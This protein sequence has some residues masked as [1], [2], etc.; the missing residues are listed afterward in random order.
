MSSL[1]ARHSR[2]RRLLFALSILFVLAALL[3]ATTPLLISGPGRDFVLDRINA[4][5]AGRIELDRL[6]LDWTGPQRIRGMRVFDPAGRRVLEIGAI[7]IDGSLP[8]LV[9]S[10]QCGGGVTIRDGEAAL[11]IGDDGAT[12]LAGVFESSDPSEDDASSGFESLRGIDCRLHLENFELGLSAPGMEQITITDLAVTADLQ[13]LD[14]LDLQF[15]ATLIQA[16]TAGRVAG[17][18]LGQGL[19]D[20]SGRPAPAGAEFGLFFEADQFPVDII[21]RLAGLDGR[22]RA[23][24]GAYLSQRAEGQWRGNGGRFTLDSKGSGGARAQLA[25]AIRDGAVSLERPADIVL[26]IRPEAWSVL[27]PP[28]ARLTAPFDIA[29]HLEKL[30]WAPGNA[31]AALDARLLIGEIDLLAEDPR[32]GRLALRETRLSVK[33]DDLRE[34]LAIDLNTQAEQGGRGGRARLEGR[35]SDFLGPDLAPT[36][37]NLRLEIS[38][39]LTELPLAVLDQF[40]GSDGLLSGA[41]GPRMNAEFRLVSAPAQHVGE[42]D[43]SAQSAYLRAGFSGRLDA[44]GLRLDTGVVGLDVQPALVA[45]LT[46]AISLASQ[47]ELNLELQRFRVPRRAELLAWDEA[48]F[49]LVAEVVQARA[50]AMADG[51]PV[52]LAGTLNAGSARLADGMGFAFDGRL[53]DDQGDGRIRVT[54]ALDGALNL[55]ETAR[56][57]LADFPVGVI[58]RL[59]GQPGRIA[60]MLG[61]SMALELALECLAEGGLGIGLVLESALMKSRLDAHHDGERL[62]LAAGS[63]MEWQLTSEALTAIQSDPRWTMVRPA[64]MVVR[65]D[66]LDAAVDADGIDMRSL[67]LA[68]EARMPEF[69]IRRGD[70]A[71]LRF[72][73]MSIVASG[74]PLAEQLEL[75][76][77]AQLAGGGFHSENTISGLVDGSGM[78]AIGRARIQTETRLDDVPGD[79]L[80]ALGGLDPALGP[81]LGP[82][83]RARVSGRVPG[84]LEVHAEGVNTRV[85]AHAS[86][87]ADGVLGLDRDAELALNVTPALVD[88]YLALLHPFLNEVQSAE[89]PIRLLLSADGFRIPLAEYR[90]QEIRARGRLEIGTLNMNRGAITLALFGALRELGGDLRPGSTFQARFTPLEF[91]VADGQV[92]TNDL[93]MQMGEIMLGAQGTVRLPER[94]DGVPW[95]EMV[96]A[97]PGQTLRGLPRFADSIPPETILTTSA[98]GPLDEISPEFSRFFARLMTQWVIERATGESEI[99]QVIGDLLRGAGGGTQARPQGESRSSWPNMPPIETGEEPPGGGG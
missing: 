93:W 41:L 8:R 56:L 73:G 64:L 71:P 65:F 77:S 97:L 42:F 49:E 16:G 32:I 38:G 74:L 5:L 22:L 95:A 66:R 80:M 53:G 21:D 47:A 98:A 88:G 54:A 67:G 69:V 3:V 44:D 50:Q 63:E 82:T 51:P 68:A 46:D 31:V 20:A 48:E 24:L 79:M 76:A 86:L 75:R 27:A 58:D 62:S 34:G 4:T 9:T 23:L 92:R 30:A 18:A 7:D 40:V 96:F 17:R 85:T 2:L 61:E 33:S 15:D 81:A 36:P 26:G 19:F 37:G 89:Q 13:G 94:V 70:E 55:R 43:L 90:P 39:D 52:H 57:E 60:A 99:G 83:V 12:N 91:S 10:S 29:V 59:T 25:F 11:I 45:S 78:L 6:E 14:A 1:R 84:E 72:S 35:V 28:G 87:D